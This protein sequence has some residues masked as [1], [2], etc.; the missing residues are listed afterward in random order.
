MIHT[1]TRTHAHTQ[2][3][4]QC[5]HMAIVPAWHSCASQWLPVIDVTRPSRG[6]H[7][8]LAPQASLVQAQAGLGEAAAPAVCARVQRLGQLHHTV[9]RAPGRGGA[10]PVGQRCQHLGGHHP[11]VTSHHITSHHITSHHI[12]SHGRQHA[13]QHA[14]QRAHTAA[15]RRLDSQVRWASQEVE[16]ICL[17]A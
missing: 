13:P 7:T 6:H 1:H 5:S 15:Q 10:E 8:R 2:R 12:T 17:H 3:A 14:P 11:C 16:C 9:A 4:V